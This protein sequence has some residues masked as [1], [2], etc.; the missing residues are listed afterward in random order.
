MALSPIQKELDAEKSRVLNRKL[1]GRTIKVI[2]IANGWRVVQP[3]TGEEYSFP[4]LG[5]AIESYDGEPT[6]VIEYIA[7]YFARQEKERED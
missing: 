2:R 3:E 6:T 1:N 7:D 5:F 4:S